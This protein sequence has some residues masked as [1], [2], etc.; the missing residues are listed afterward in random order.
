[1]V[2]SGI[3]IITFI[4][5]LYQKNVIQNNPRYQPLMYLIQAAQYAGTMLTS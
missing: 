3:L 5:N 4:F 1:M 2:G